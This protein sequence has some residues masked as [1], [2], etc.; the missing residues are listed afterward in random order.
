MSEKEINDLKRRQCVKCQYLSRAG[1]NTDRTAVAQLTCDY[2]AVHGHTRGCD[3]RDCV[4]K[5][6]FKKRKGARRKRAKCPHSMGDY[7]RKGFSRGF[8]ACLDTIME[9]NHGE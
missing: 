1:A 2:I 8:N 5:G 3:P 4:E 6:V 7:Q 9:D